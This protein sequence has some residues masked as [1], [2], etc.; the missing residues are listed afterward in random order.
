MIVELG[1]DSPGVSYFVGYI[2]RMSN[3]EYCEDIWQKSFYD[4]IIKD[5][6]DY[7]YHL[8]Y[9]EENPK[10]WKMGKDKYYS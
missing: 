9:I 6:E 3:S 2:K 8:Q 7:Y 10:K 1:E 4:H 5:D